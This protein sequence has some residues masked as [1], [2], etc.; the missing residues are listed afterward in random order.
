MRYMTAGESHGPALTA[1]VDGVPAGLKI[2]EDQINSDLARRQSGYGRGGRQAI[3]RDRVAVTAG[4]RFG[5]T[6]GSPVALV[7]ANRDWENWTDRMAAFGDV[8]SDLARE[9]CPR[10]GHADL[11]GALKTNT[12]D[13]RN[14]LERASARET[15]ARVAAAGIAR[16]FL[17]ELGVE[18]FSYVASIG[19]AS[20]DED[21]PMLAAP[22]YKPLDIELSDVRCPSVE[23][24]EAMK[25]EIDAAREA[26]ESLGGTFRV[27]ATGLL[28]GVGG[29][30]TAGERLTSRIGGALFSIPAIKGVEFGLGFEAA[31]RP[32]SQV[33][34]PITV[35][36]KA[37]F[38]RTRNNAGGLEG[39]MTTGMPLIVTAAMKP[40]PT[41]MTPLSTV[42]LDTLEPEEA[43]RERSDVCA[44]PACAVVAEAEVAFAL[45][46][47]YLEKFGHDNMTDIKAA[48]KS[49]RQRL[50]TISR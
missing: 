19:G 32:G 33:H 3:E 29:Y 13:C 39:G 18:V 46:D 26:G 27:V 2:S 5:R 31:R 48:V 17:A 24:T 12:D 1:I 21:D 44:V 35:D 4:V 47:A 34:D 23:A 37:G 10:P 36:R 28:P 43:S 30:A 11:V 45:A 14:I 16:E 49:Y 15:A 6:I 25:A 7:V 9:V 8:P 20:L 42:N 22:D 41:L 50:R 40:I 38:T